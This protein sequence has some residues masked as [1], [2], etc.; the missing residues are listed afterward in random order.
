[1][2]IATD[3]PVVLEQASQQFVEATAVPPFIYEL[4]PAEARKVLDD[5]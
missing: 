4:T 2:S 5:V 1:M 3:T